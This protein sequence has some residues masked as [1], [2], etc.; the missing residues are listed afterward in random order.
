MRL[1][2]VGSAASYAGAGQACSSYLVSTDTARILLDCGNGSL[3]NLARVID[4]LTL[5]AVFV[6]H[7]HPDHFLDLFALQAAIRYAPSGPAKVGP[8]PLY[9]PVGLPESMSCMLDARGL[10]DLHAAF[11]WRQLAPGE[12]VVIGD[13]TV[14]PMPVD[15]IPD[16]FALRIA[17]GT[18]TLCY[19]SDSRFGPQVL[20]AARGADVVLSEATLPQEYAGRG[21]HMTAEE[22]GELGTASSAQ[23]LILTH[24]WPTADRDDLLAGARR[25]FSG[26]VVLAT[27]MLTVDLA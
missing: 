8:M 15:H 23:G 17:D 21:P 20:D 22:A 13:L 2:V 5:D 26:E 12:P 4:P 6:T 7:R 27:E 11:S 1:T 9:G 19:T 24:L 25:T 10:D 14:T 18:V 16:T 3:A